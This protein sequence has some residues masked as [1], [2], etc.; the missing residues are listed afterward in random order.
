M[1]QDLFDVVDVEGRLKGDEERVGGF[2]LVYDNGYVEMAQHDAA[3]STYLG[4][5]WDMRHPGGTASGATDE[6]AASRAAQA[7]PRKGHLSPDGPPRADPEP[8]RAS[9]SKGGAGARPSSTGKKEKRQGR[10]VAGGG[11]YL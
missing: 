4:A 2:D 3:W 9:L 7:T 8:R 11:G 10:A 6:R 1:L 5:K